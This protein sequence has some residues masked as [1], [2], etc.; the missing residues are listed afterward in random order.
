MGEAQRKN[1]V[2]VPIQ[3]MDELLVSG[4]RVSL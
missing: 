3:E 2:M 4:R 1:E